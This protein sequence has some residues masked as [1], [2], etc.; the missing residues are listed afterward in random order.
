MSN[1][2]EYK[3]LL[4]N[5]TGRYPPYADRGDVLVQVYS[6]D[7]IEKAKKKAIDA[8][9]YGHDWLQGNGKVEVLTIEKIE[10]KRHPA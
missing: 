1:D 10:R 2:I 7:D 4:R 9:A 3:V 8:Y 6:T 5:N